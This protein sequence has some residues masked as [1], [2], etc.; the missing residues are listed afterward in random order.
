MS[1]SGTIQKCR[2]CDKTVHFVEMI[3]ADGIPYHNTCFRCVKCN[4]KLAVCISSYIYS[5]FKIHM[6]Y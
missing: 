3:S 5:L 4:G 6:L 2:A 1:F